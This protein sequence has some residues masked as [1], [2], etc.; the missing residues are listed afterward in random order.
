MTE[1]VKTGDTISVTY[2]G[3]IADGEVFDSNAEGGRP[4]KFTV[5]AGQLIPGFDRA[6]IGMLPGGRKTVTISPSEGYGE[7]RPD[8]IVKVPRDRVPAEMKLALGMQVQLTGNTGQT[9]T[10][11]VVDIAEDVVR[12]DAN[13]PLAGKTLEF[14]IEIRETGL[15]PDP[16]QGCGCDCD[17]SQGCGDGCGGCGEA[18]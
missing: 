17:T 7:H 1:A 2:T 9:L 10:A 5:G 12:L 13:H 14:D 18:H 8:H 16:H 15:A 4:L 3:R 6:V 11:V